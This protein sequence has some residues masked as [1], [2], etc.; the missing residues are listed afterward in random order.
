MEGGY[1]TPRLGHGLTFDMTEW[2]QG[3]L[4]VE[5]AGSSS[6]SSAAPP[7]VLTFYS[8]YR[9]Y[10][11]HCAPMQEIEA[12]VTWAADALA[13]DAGLAGPLWLAGRQALMAFCRGAP[14]YESLFLLPEAVA[15][16]VTPAPP[17]P[18]PSQGQRPEA[19]QRGAGRGRG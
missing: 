8:P 10:R 6:S 17:C 5:P 7:F 16:A 15:A 3:A 13:R 18:W 4:H 11:E 14:L 9:T 1:A 19:S 12:D 2:R